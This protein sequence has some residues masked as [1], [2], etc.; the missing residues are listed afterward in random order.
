M[1]VGMKS[2]QQALPAIHFQVSSNRYFKTFVK[3]AMNS[4]G[5]SM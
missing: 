2:G 5:F 4:S 3:V 1:P